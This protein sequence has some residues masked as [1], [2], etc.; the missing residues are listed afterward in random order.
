LYERAVEQAAVRTA[1]TDTLVSDRGITL[2]TPE[3]P[4]GATYRQELQDGARL[5]GPPQFGSE[6][7]VPIS[8]KRITY[9]TTM[10]SRTDLC[11]H[12]EPVSG[13]CPAAN[14]EVML[15]QR[16]AGALHLAVGQKA[17]V[18]LVAQQPA[19]PGDKP[20]A[21]RAFRE[22]KGFAFLHVPALGRSYTVPVVQGVSL[23]DLARGVGHYPK[24]ALPGRVGNFAV[25]GHRA[26]NGEPFAHLDK[27]GKGDVVVVETRDT[28]YTYVVDRSRIV[29]PSD[30]W[31]I[32]PV[33]G[34]TGVQPTRRLL[35]LTTCNPRWASTER[36][37][38]F[39]HLQGQ[40]P[41]TDGRP[42]VLASGG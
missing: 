32:D 24:T 12:L 36:L 13:R 27:V 16:L 7:S 17:V 34:R 9:Q 28:W 39:G 5:F 2:N 15:S 42:T 40:Q 26:T 18:T 19:P 8:N 38:V 30:T 21:V 20:V 41:R 37:I 31:V 10:T 33:P 6:L 3:L 25:A 29:A 4:T 23:P 14:N 35:T 11:P 22:G 1:L